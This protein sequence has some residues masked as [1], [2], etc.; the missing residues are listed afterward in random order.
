MLDKMR[1]ALNNVDREIVCRWVTDLVL[2]K[3][4]V[5]LRAERTILERAAKVLGTTY[6]P[7][8]PEDE[9]RGVDGYLGDQPVSVKPES[10]KNERD[11]INET[12]DVK[13]IY[14][15]KNNGKIVADI[16]QVAAS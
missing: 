11:R 1:D 12:I 6:H 15:K 16:S 9:S 3:T 8:S 2:Q 4:Y 10:Y 7:S 13:M 14:Y 5:G